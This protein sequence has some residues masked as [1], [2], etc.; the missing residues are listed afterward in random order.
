MNLRTRQFVAGTAMCL[1]A[2]AGL[3]QVVAKVDG[4]EV[5]QTQL[6]V[7][8]QGRTGA[9]ATED[10]REALVD[11]IADLI[12]LSNLAVE[13]GLDQKAETAANIELNRRSVLAQAAIN[14]F[15]DTNE[16]TDEA[17]QEEYDRQIGGVPKPKEFKARHILVETEDDAKALIAELDGG[18]DF[19]ELAKER[20]TGPSG[21]QGGDLGWFDSNAMVAPFSAAVAALE[22][23]AY[24]KAPV[25]TQ[26]GWHVILREGDRDGSLPGFE[27]V[28]EQL[29]S[30]MQQ[31]QFQD[32][33]Q[34]LKSKAS[35]EMTE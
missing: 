3:T 5:T 32:Y 29:R 13:Q 18:A 21:P 6:N 34:D 35:V 23:G 20:S 26:F 11:Q 19:A 16:I 12:V 24:S 17:L 4:V 14:H 15:V 1:L 9:A 28:K 7:F 33:F 27:E 25:Q 31:Q 10:N 30:A 22:N 8:S 2:Q